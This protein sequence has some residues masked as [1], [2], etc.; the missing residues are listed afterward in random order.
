MSASGLDEDAL[1]AEVAAGAEAPKAE[2]LLP[3][4]VSTMVREGTGLPVRVVTTDVETDRGDPCLGPA[5]RERRALEAGGLG[6]PPRPALVD[7]AVTT[8]HS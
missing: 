6:S 7:A 1:L 8:A 4:V 5:D 2:V 3:E